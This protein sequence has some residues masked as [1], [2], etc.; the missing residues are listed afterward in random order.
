MFGNFFVIVDLAVALS[1]G[2]ENYK[3]KL[4]HC[5]AILSV[6]RSNLDHYFNKI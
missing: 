5:Y 6:I 1:K 3:G 2:R 4:K